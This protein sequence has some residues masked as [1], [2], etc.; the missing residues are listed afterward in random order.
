[1]II[2]DLKSYRFELFWTRY[3]C[4]IKACLVFVVW[5]KVF[6]HFCCS[7]L[8]RYRLVSWDP[9][10]TNKL[11]PLPG[12]RERKRERELQMK[13]SGNWKTCKIILAE[14]YLWNLFEGWLSQRELLAPLCN[15][16]KR[17]LR[18]S[19]LKVENINSCIMVTLITWSIKISAF[20]TSV[21]LS[22]EQLKY[23]HLQ[24]E[25]LL[26]RKAH[27]VRLNTKS[28]WSL[29]SSLWVMAF[30]RGGLPNKTIASISLSEFI[31]T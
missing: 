16:D 5:I 8:Q 13:H 9:T 3:L 14:T 12:L 30:S 1:M 15:G 27:S 21:S 22:L 18:S 28:A 29:L 25:G 31:F 2:L 17:V 6:F 23:R 11:D 19:E 7:R 4:S 24:S 26:C 10:N 20:E